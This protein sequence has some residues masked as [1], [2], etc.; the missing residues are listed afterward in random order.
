MN[1]AMGEIYAVIPAGA[2]HAVAFFARL[3]VASAWGRQQYGSDGFHI[4]RA[5]IVERGDERPARPPMGNE[6]GRA[7]C[8]D[9]LY[10]RFGTTVY[11]R[12][13]QMLG[14]AA[15]ARDAAREVLLRA[16]QVLDRIRDS[17][18]AFIHVYRTATNHCLDEIRNGRTPAP[19]AIVSQGP[20]P[21]AELR[22]GDQDLVA[23]MIRQLPEELA[24]TAWLYHVDQLALT[25]IAELCGVS[26]HTVVARLAHFQ[27]QAPAFFLRATG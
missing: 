20:D 1:S 2:A 11:A 9:E 25:E 14:E 3:E 22:L 17:R 26:R 16:C 4:R 5:G 6:D 8:F 23:R 10:D 18:E 21:G 7:E 12:C 13:R 19:R 27:E 15:L 24:I